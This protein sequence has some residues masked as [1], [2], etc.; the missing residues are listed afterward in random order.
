MEFYRLVTVFAAA[1]A[2][3]VMSVQKLHQAL[4]RELVQS[5]YQM[6]ISAMPGSYY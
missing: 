3:Q 1:A 6:P 4:T 2:A 5:W